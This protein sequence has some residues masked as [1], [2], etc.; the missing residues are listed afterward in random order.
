M[1]QTV[2]TLD[3]EDLIATAGL[4]GGRGGCSWTETLAHQQPTSGP[5]PPP[6]TNARQVTPDP[7]KLTNFLLLCLPNL[8]VKTCLSIC[9][10]KETLAKKERAQLAKADNGDGCR[11][12]QPGG[13]EG[14]GGRDGL[15]EEEEGGGNYIWKAIFIQFLPRKKT[16]IGAKKKLKINVNNIYSKSRITQ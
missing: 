6:T 11:Q 5:P 14:G 4:S 3:R 1:G 8:P 7:G 9:S 16:K 12:G 13:G 10:Q 15:E 2:N